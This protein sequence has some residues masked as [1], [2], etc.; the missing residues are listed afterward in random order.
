MIEVKRTRRKRQKW[1][2]GDYFLI[3]LSNKEFTIGQI[4]GRIAEALNSVICVYFDAKVKTEEE[5]FEKL[6][7]YLIKM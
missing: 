5:A 2:I 4:I 1:Q 7:K 3:P 6:K